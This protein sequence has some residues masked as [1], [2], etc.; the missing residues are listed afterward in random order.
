MKKII[1]TKKSPAPIGPYNQ[2]I[3]KDNTKKK[4]KNINNL[5]IYNRG[6]LLPGAPNFVSII[7]KFQQLAII[8]LRKL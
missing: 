6:V 7:L 2:A 8:K 4:Q 5:F 1:N 3:L